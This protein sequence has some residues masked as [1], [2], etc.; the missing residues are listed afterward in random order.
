MT[1]KR[2]WEDGAGPW[3]SWTEQPN[4]RVPGRTLRSFRWR[5]A[6]E[7][8]GWGSWTTSPHDGVRYD[9]KA[10]ALA[11]IAGPRRRG[12][13]RHAARIDTFPKKDEKI[14]PKD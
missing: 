11:D 8:P 2:P 13:T 1:A 6:S 10:E 7:T 5:P 12:L 9:T 3:V 14:S 4:Q